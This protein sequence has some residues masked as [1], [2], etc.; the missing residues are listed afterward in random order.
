M[1]TIEHQRMPYSPNDHWLLLEKMTRP[2][3]DIIIDVN[4]WRQSQGR[5]ATYSA[6][7]CIVL[8][9]FNLSSQGVLGHFTELHESESEE[10]LDRA[11]DAI[12]SLGDTAMTYIWLGAGGLHFS[13]ESYEE[14]VAGRAVALGKAKSLNPGR[15]D[16]RWL[17]DGEE[18]MHVD[19]DPP[20]AHLLVR[21][22][23]SP[24]S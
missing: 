9:A 2:K 23:L 5:L 6:A 16:V 8:A 3:S 19:L 18:A 1:L 7:A 11:V 15:L 12:R 13:E 17:R 24:L 20:T 21:T 4:D 10:E 14:A 22:E